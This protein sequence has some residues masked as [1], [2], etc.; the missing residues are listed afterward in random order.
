MRVIAAFMP[1]SRSVA[2]LNKYDS[3][4][5]MTPTVRIMSDA[6]RMNSFSRPMNLVSPRYMTL[7]DSSNVIR[8]VN[9]PIQLT[10]NGY[11]P[12]SSGVSIR[13]N[14]GVNRNAIPRSK[15]PD[16]VYHKDAI[17]GADILAD[18]ALFVFKM[19]FP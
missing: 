5:A 9:N 3:A 2:P 8:T 13:V 16:A 11:S 4:S 1:V 17:A 14:T 18:N 6:E 10:Y 7:P 19:Q 12:Y 15:I